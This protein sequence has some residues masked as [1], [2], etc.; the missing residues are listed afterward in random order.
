MRPRATASLAVVDRAGNAAA[1]LGSA[2]V[3]R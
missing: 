3:T 2:R 1:T